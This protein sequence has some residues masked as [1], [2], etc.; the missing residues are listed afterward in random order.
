MASSLKFATLST[1]TVS[2]S[3]VATKHYSIARVWIQSQHEYLLCFFFEIS[4]DAR[5]TC[6]D[7]TLSNLSSLVKVYFSYI[8][9]KEATDMLLFF[10]D[11]DQHSL[12]G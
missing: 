5:S 2:Q 1:L 8:R 3:V 4:I 11:T 7:P 10:D 9:L 12:K 6:K